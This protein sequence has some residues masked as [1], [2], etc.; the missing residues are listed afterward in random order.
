M[1]PEVGISRA[2]RAD[3]DDIW[4]VGISRWGLLQAER[5]AQ[6]FLDSIELLR[7]HPNMGPARDD[8]APGLRHLL[9]QRHLILYRPVGDGIQIMRVLHHSMD[10]ARH[11]RDT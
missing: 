5:Y 4:K 1:L 2:A 7:L 8:L 11:L 6:A 3:L 10:L 9:V